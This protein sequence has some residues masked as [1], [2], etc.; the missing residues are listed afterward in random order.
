MLI[1]NTSNMAQAAPPARFTGDGAPNAVVAAPPN[2]EAKPAA[3]SEL[4]QAA[5]K[6]VAE[7]QPSAA[8]L[9]NVVDNIN[10][11][12]KQSNKNLEFSVDADTKK[13]VVKVVDTE[14]GDLI[15]QFPSEEALAISRAIDQMQQ[16]LLLK[17]KA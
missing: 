6:Q 12:L 11:A 14:T 15:R 3:S 7:Q 13:S 2:V 16:G 17:Q 9:Q 5:A 10:R 8:Q 1:Q 4:A